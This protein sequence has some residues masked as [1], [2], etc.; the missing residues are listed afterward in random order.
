MIALYRNFFLLNNRNKKPGEVGHFAHV[1]IITYKH[2]N[3]IR[4]RYL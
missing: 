3:R 4:M 2:I 1:V